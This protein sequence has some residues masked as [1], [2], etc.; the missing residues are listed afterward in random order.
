MTIGGEAGFSLFKLLPSSGFFK[1]D[2]FVG[3]HVSGAMG[4]LE[5]L[6]VQATPIP[7]LLSPDLQFGNPSL[8]ATYRFTDGDVEVGGRAKVFIPVAKGRKFFM[9]AGAPVL[10]H[11]GDDMRLDTG[12]TFAFQFD[13]GHVGLFN[14]DDVLS[15]EPG[16]PLKLTAQISEQI[17]AG[18]SSG[19]GILDFDKA[20]DT[21]FI[22]LGLH[23][24]YTLVKDGR[25]LADLKAQFAFPLFLLPGN[26]RD[27]VAEDVYFFGLAA[28][29]YYS[30]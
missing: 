23:G 29:A 11:L 21:L 13:P 26:S 14:Y 24:G 3:V 17:F 7:L 15:Y 22:P 18:G 1:S 5:N 25:P 6:E 12:A 20:G 4:V 19:F 8:G 28:R 10:V 16:V 27:A 9:M 2:P 30:L